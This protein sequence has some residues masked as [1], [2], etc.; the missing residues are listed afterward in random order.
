VGSI[1]AISLEVG[2]LA[3]FASNVPISRPINT[4]WT[5]DW[6]LGGGLKWSFDYGM[7]YAPQDDLIPL[8][9]PSPRQDQ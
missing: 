6:D 7:F 3:D 5:A 4:G 8:R 1:S 9:K 2:K